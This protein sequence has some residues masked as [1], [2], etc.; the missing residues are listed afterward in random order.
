MT[1]LDSPQV[2]TI[3][4]VRTTPAV[5]STECDQSAAGCPRPGDYSPPHLRGQSEKCLQISSISRQFS[6]VSGIEATIVQGQTDKTDKG[7]C[8]FG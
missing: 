3:P 4:A 8:M 1:F 5:E 7:K 6:Q 2:R